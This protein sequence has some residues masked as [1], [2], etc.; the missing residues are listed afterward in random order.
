MHRDDPNVPVSD[1]IDFLDS[2]QKQGKIRYYG[3]SNWSLPRI[4]EAAEYAKQSGKQGF[5]VNQIMWSLA[6]VNFNNLADKTF[7]LMDDEMYKYHVKTGMNVMAYMS[8]AKAYFA[9]KFAGENLPSDVTNVYANPTNE[10]IYSCCLDTVKTEA[11]SFMDL[12][13]MYIMGQSEFTAVP[14]ASFDNEQQLDTGI[15]T[16][17][18]QIPGDLIRQLG[19]IK[20]FVYFD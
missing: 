19:E 17:K 10:Q 3:C 4:K 16:C 9:R 12:S 1:I 14:I 8:I 11:Y 5:V 20:K 7:I 6:D 18:K 2:A 13:F 15:A